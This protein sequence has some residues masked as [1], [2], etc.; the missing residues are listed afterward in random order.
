MTLEECGNV[1]YYFMNDI[2][3]LKNVADVIEICDNVKRGIP[4]YIECLVG[5]DFERHIWSYNM[6]KLETEQYAKYLK[7]ITDDDEMIFYED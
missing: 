3:A 7:Q 4:V 1:E 5:E 6:N 2:Y